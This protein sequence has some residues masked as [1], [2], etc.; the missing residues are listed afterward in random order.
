MLVKAVVL[1][2]HQA[3]Q[4]GVHLGDG[5]DDLGALQLELLQALGAAVAALGA[6]RIR[7]IRAEHVEGAPHAGVAGEVVEH[8]EAADAK[9]SAIQAGRGALAVVVAGAQQI[10]RGDG[11]IPGHDQAVLVVAVA[12]HGLQIDRG[13]A[14]AQVTLLRLPG[15]QPGEL[16]VPRLD[17]RLEEDPVA[18]VGL[19]QRHGLG[20]ARH[21][22]LGRLHQ[23]GAVSEHQVVAPG[24]I[25]VAEVAAYLEG[26]VGVK[27]YPHPFVTLQGPGQG[28]PLQYPQRRGGRGGALGQGCQARRA[29]VKQGLE[30]GV[31]VILLDLG[32]QTD[33]G[34]RLDV[35][36]LAGEVLVVEVDE[37]AV[38]RLGVA[39]PLHIQQV[40][41]LVEAFP[42]TRDHRLD[43]D[44]LGAF[45]LIVRDEGALVAAALDG[46]DGGEGTVGR[47]TE[48]G[49]VERRGREREPHGQ[50]QQGRCSF[51]GYSFFYFASVSIALASWPRARIVTFLAALTSEPTHIMRRQ[52]SPSAIF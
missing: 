4:V 43:R 24:G 30:L 19:G 38:R 50:R 27:A 13:I 33:Q 10:P 3:E 40:E 49:G 23:R 26:A 46:G 44:A 39:V 36:V 41:A 1:H 31:A 25:V 29:A 22:E 14:D 34:A 8:V 20:A 42:Q 2:L 17:V 48:A 32:L 51:H 35:R 37:N 47:A 7:L 18:G 52:R 15:G 45:E 11:L 21:M 6:V 9:V 28:F 16:A 5:V 12:D